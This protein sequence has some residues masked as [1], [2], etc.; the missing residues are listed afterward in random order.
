MSRKNEREKARRGGNAFLKPGYLLLSFGIS[1]M[2]WVSV[3]AFIDPEETRTVNNIPVVFLHE[4]TQLASRGLIITEGKDTLLSIA[5]RGSRSKL[6][7][8]SS[9]N[10]SV[11]IDL[12][13]VQTSGLRSMNY[14]PIIPDALRGSVSVDW[15]Y[16]WQRSPYVDIRVDQLVPATFEVKLRREGPVAE[17]HM[18]ETAILEPAVVTVEGPAEMIEHIEYVE[19]ILKRDLFE[20]SVEHELLPFTYRT[21]GGEEIASPLISGNVAGI[22]V[23]LPI[24]MTKKVPLQLSFEPGGGASEKNVSAVIT[25]DIVTVSG[26]ES[27]LDRLNVINLPAVDLVSLPI[28]ASVR[29]YPIVIPNGLKIVDRTAEATVSF[30]LTG[31]K[32]KTLLLNT[33]N[34]RIAGTIPPG[35]EVLPVTKEISVTI[36]GPAETVELIGRSNVEV[37]VDL[38]EQDFMPMAGLFTARATVRCPSYP[39][40]GTVDSY[41]VDI[42]LVPESEGA[43]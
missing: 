26:N 13:H 22:S 40:A 29:S 33:D 14:N 8:L 5:F 38:N 25:P 24:V 36:R 23:S 43:V 4:D 34:I 3:V 39:S 30:E 1:F 16:Q 20:T 21:A 2:L 9:E 37:V 15:T 19:V 17:N 42:E 41:T 18:A 12:A 32:E 7:Q 28:G 31:L 35:F 11:E 6:A 27:E 10:V